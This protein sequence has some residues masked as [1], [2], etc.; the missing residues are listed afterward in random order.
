MTVQRELDTKTPDLPFV[1]GI[2]EQIT[3]G[4]LGT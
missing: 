2:N 3:A 1:I 4:L